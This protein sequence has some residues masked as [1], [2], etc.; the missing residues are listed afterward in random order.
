M[1]VCE[2]SER[3][4]LKQA[5]VLLK[6]DMKAWR[7]RGSKGRMDQSQ[8][9]VMVKHTGDIHEILLMFSVV[10]LVKL[11]LKMLIAMIN[12]PPYCF[13]APHGTFS[14]R[15]KVENEDLWH[16]MTVVSF[17]KLESHF[18]TVATAHLQKHT[19]QKARVLILLD[20]FH[21]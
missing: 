12:L 21:S 17:S 18:Y 5:L 8:V 14:H 10:P 3:A 2:P 15:A 11:W 16:F 13:L 6:C 9:S 1:C 20:I 7:V 4:A 19:S